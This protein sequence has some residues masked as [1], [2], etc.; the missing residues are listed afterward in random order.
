M[1]GGFR[2]LSYSPGF[3]AR[4]A[5]EFDRCGYLDFRRFPSTNPSLSI[6]PTHP[7]RPPSDDESL[8]LRD[9]SDRI[10]DKKSLTYFH[11]ERLFPAHT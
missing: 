9:F 10:R 2:G 11:A 7:Q 1:R 6:S 8:L 3:A 4:L 5:I